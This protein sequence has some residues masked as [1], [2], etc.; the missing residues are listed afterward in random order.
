MRADF[1]GMPSHRELAETIASVRAPTSLRT[2]VENTRRRHAPPVRPRRATLAGALASLAA[3]AGVALAL[4]HESPPQPTVAET[5]ILS[6]R[7]AREPSPRPSTAEPNRLDRKAEGIWYPN[8]NPAGWRA[9]GARTDELGGR[10][11]TTVF[12][13][14][15]EKRIG[16]TILSGNSLAPPADARASVRKGIQ[17]RY[18]RRGDRSIVMWERNGRSCILSGAHVGREVMLALVGRTVRST[19]SSYGA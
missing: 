7:P 6:T 18:L 5:A 17:L 8:W 12:Y 15:G 11:A 4:T 14:K 3:A 2:R 13:A 16:Y 9:A 19:P 1:P 10:R